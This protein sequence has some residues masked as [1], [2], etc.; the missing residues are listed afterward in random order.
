MQW[1]PLTVRCMPRSATMMP[2]LGVRRMVWVAGE[3]MLA[4]YREVVDTVLAFR[5]SKE[6]LIRRAVI[7]LIPRLASFAPERFAV[8]YLRPCT[9][10]CCPQHLDSVVLKPA[11]CSHISWCSIACTIIKAPLV[12]SL[13]K[14]LVSH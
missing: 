10:G 9:G 7:T 5:E 12:A 4:R 13:A 8:A 3:F 11:L 6:R 1:A 14:S 2:C